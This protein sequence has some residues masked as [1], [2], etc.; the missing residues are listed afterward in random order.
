MTWT[1]ELE[2]PRPLIDV[3][4]VALRASLLDRLE[5]GLSLRFA[6]RS[7]N[8]IGHGSAQVNGNVGARL[9]ELATARKDLKS[10]SRK[11]VQVR[12]LPSAPPNQFDSRDDARGPTTLAYRSL[13]KEILRRFTA[14]FH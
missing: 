10:P 14:T 9:N 1:L 7:D 11:G 6:P 8:R 13:G 12:V 3:G 2:V 4:L 5:G